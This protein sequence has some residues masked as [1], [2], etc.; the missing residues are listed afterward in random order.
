[1]LL[2]ARASGIVN[3][4]TLPHISLEGSF[5]LKCRPQSIAINSDSA[6]ISVIDINGVFTL[7]KLEAGE[8]KGYKTEQ[9]AIERKDVWDMRWSSDNPDPFAILEKQRMYVFRDL[10]PEE[11]VLSSACKC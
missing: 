5:E 9:Q 3:I 1:M 2:V 6:R 11:P 4:Y 8:Q 10:D 7:Y